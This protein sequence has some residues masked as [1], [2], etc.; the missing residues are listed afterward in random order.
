M[1]DER[2]PVLIVGGGPVGL[3]TALL[4]AQ[5]GIHAQLV[6]KHVGTAIGPRARGINVRSMEIFRSAGVEEE[7]RQAGARVG[8]E[9]Y[10]LIVE[11]LAGKELRRSG[12]V[13]VS[14]RTSMLS[15]S[16]F[17]LCAQNELEPCLVAATQGTTSHLYFGMEMLFLREEVDGVR[18]EVRERAS[19]VRRTIYARYVVAADGPYSPTRELLQVGTSGAGDMG[20]YI[21]IYFRADLQALVRNRAFVMCFVQNPFVRGTL[22][23]VNNIDLWTL[24]VAY[25]PQ[26]ESHDD[27]TAERCM[28]LVRQAIGLP[29]LDVE[30]LDIDSWVAAAN[31]ADHFQVGRVFFVGDAAHRM[32]PAGAFGMNT[33][34]QD[35]HNLAW[36]LAAVIRGQATPALL[37]SY[38]EERQPV[39][40]ETVTQASTQLETAQRQ[41]QSADQSARDS[42]ATILGY[43]YRSAAIIDPEQDKRMYVPIPDTVQLDAMPGTRAPHIW[44]EQQGRPVSILDL[45][46]TSFVLLTDEHNLAWTEVA[47]VLSIQQNYPLIAFRV[48]VHGDLIDSK[49]QWTAGYHLSKDGAVLIRP[50]GFVAWRTDEKLADP[51]QILAHVLKQML[52]R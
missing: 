33:G 7:I 10:T 52:G 35:A 19:G 14:E 18:V 20:H 24:N 46:S 4:L 45:F 9:R 32:P 34:I 43:R 42:M 8:D 37:R 41:S 26:H 2:I 47:H 12:G 11:T 40:R 16:G 5:Q 3:T 22:I 17:C 51:R 23:A 48:G 28:K 13:T 29:D 36:K 6:E 39:A 44:L 30:L 21:N 50:D 15:P 27:F 31:L 49:R 38:E 25:D 1:Q